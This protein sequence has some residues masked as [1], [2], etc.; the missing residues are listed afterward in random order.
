MKLGRISSFV[1]RRY[2]N[3]PAAMASLFGMRERLWRNNIPFETQFWEKYLDTRGGPQWS[4]GYNRRIDPSSA[5]DPDV[6]RFLKDE[7]IT[8]LDV[9]AGP[10]TILV[11][12]WNGQRVRITAVDPLAKEYDAMLAK[13]GIVPAVRTQEGRAEELDSIF[14]PD[15]FD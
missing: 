14:A 12:V 15:S 8:V 11:Y 4:T 5:F 10:I 6:G 13:R 2:P 7:N 1:A 3:L 9:G